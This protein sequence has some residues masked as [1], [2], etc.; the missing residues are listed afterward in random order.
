MTKEVNDPLI[1]SVKAHESSYA[2]YNALSKELFEYGSKFFSNFPDNWI[3]E[4]WIR[5]PMSDYKNV[6]RTRILMLPNAEKPEIKIYFCVRYHVTWRTYD[7]VL[8]DSAEDVAFNNQFGDRFKK[9]DLVEV[10][11]ELERRVGEK[12]ISS[13]MKKSQ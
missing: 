2:P 9:M 4:H 7:V 6:T 3:E 12:Y 11:K 8:S 10:K 1:E 5:D 13:Q